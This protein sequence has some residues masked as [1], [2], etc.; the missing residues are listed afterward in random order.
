MS[1]R[2]PNFCRNS[3]SKNAPKFRKKIREILARGKAAPRPKYAKIE[4][5]TV[6]IGFCRVFTRQ[7]YIIIVDID[8]IRPNLGL[9]WPTLVEYE[10]KSR[11]FG[12]QNGPN[13]GTSGIPS[14]SEVTVSVIVQPKFLTLSLL[15]F[16]EPYCCLLLLFNSNN[17][18]S[19]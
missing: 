10:N 6:H 14:H 5:E 19:P 1:R 18:N 3:R 2:P 9:I 17:K 15:L 13:L 11:S 16:T 8:S 12:G 4:E 7:S